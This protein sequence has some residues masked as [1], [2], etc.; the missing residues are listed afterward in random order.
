MQAVGGWARIGLVARRAV[1]VWVLALVTI[2]KTFLDTG[3]NVAC[4][5]R[6]DHLQQFI[7]TFTVA[8]KYMNRK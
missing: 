6:R 4:I 3:D 1:G 5:H 2:D 7:I 8:H